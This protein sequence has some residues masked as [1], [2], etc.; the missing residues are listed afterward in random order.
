MLSQLVRTTVASALHGS[1]ALARHRRWHFRDRAM[2]LMYHRILNRADVPPETEPGIYVTTEAFEQNLKLLARICDVVELD[3]LVAN[4]RLE[5]RSARPMCAITFDDGWQD[6]YQNAF[7]LLKR[8]GLPATVFLVTDQVG[9]PDMLTWSQVQEMEAGGVRF[10][11]HT[12]THRELTILTPQA[13]DWEL[14]ESRRQLEQQVA[15]PSRCFC[16]PKGYFH[17]AAVEAASRHYTA[18]VT[19]ERRAVSRDDNLFLIPRIGVHNDI[20]S[21]ESLFALRLSGLY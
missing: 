1:G 14:A 15:R 9:R 18:A 10:A 11:S 4:L 8:F 17:R 16:Y 21:S 2:V 13:L 20:A 7:P 6:N 5:P 19:T 3:V 12:V